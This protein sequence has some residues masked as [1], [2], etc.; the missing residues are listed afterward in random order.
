[1]GITFPCEIISWHVLPAVRREIAIYLA[2]EKGLSRK[3]IAEK[4][5]ITEAAVCQYIK[6]KRGNNHKFG[7]K[8]RKKI[9][10]IAERLLIAD[11]KFDKMCIVCKEFDVKETIMKN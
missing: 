10:E 6:S 5:G 4:L 2:K 3:L 1:M 7:E 11:K 8:D 9:R